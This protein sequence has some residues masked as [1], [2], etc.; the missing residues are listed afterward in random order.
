MPDC[1]KNCVLAS[2]VDRLEEDIRSEK[3]SRQKAHKEFYRCV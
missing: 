3:E 2:R 1:E